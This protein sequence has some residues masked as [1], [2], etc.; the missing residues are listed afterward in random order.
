[1]P[2][3]LSYNAFQTNIYK[4]P[5]SKKDLLYHRNLFYHHTLVSLNHLLL[6]IHP[7]RLHPFSVL[8]H[9]FAFHLS[10]KRSAQISIFLIFSK[11]LRFFFITKCTS[12]SSIERCLYE[13][14]VLHNANSTKY[15]GPFPFSVSSTCYLK[16]FLLLE[17]SKY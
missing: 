17:V 1:M 10:N 7:S 3:T 2:K 4:I 5:L 6:N 11:L 9:W 15:E 8:N 14:I 13:D 12:I 16:W